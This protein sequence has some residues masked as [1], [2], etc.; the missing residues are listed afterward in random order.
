MNGSTWTMQGFNDL[1][2][3]DFNLFIFKKSLFSSSLFS[4]FFSCNKYCGSSIRYAGVLSLGNCYYD[5]WK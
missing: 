3:S 2:F 1:V 5:L 4:M